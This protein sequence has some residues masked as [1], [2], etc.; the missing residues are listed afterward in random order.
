LRVAAIGA[1]PCKQ[2][3][4]AASFEGFERLAHQEV[5]WRVAL[6]RQDV[7]D[8]TVMGPTTRHVTDDDLGRLVARLSE[9]VGATAAVEVS[10]YRR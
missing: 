5:T 2:D 10:V 6:Y 3:R 7:H 1:D 4:L 8:V 9:V